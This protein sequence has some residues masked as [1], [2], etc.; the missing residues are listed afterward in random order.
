MDSFAFCKY[1]SYNDAANC[2]GG[3]MDK[4]AVSGA[5][6]TG[7]IP[8]RDAMSRQNKLFWRLFFYFRSRI[9]QLI[10]I[11]ALLNMIIHMTHGGC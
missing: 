2:P 4:A 3:L 7:S 1:F 9:R 8:V 10:C 11:V 5:A 6:D